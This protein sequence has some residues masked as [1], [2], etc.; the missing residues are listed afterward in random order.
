MPQQCSGPLP[1]SLTINNNNSNHLNTVES[2]LIHLLSSV[3]DLNFLTQ[4]EIPTFHLMSPFQT[5]LGVGVSRITLQLGEVCGT[6]SLH[7]HPQTDSHPQ[8]FILSFKTSFSHSCPTSLHQSP[9]VPFSSLSMTL[10]L[11]PLCVFLC[12]SL[13]LTIHNMAVSFQISLLGGSPSLVITALS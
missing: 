5:L 3:W 2:F 4:E 1:L 9:L 7:S 12:R 10:T 13:C 8:T 11:L 6:P